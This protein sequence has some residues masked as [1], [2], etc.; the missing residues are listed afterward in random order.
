LHNDEDECPCCGDYEACPDC[1]G[2]RYDQYTD[3]LL[4]CPT[5]D[6]TGMNEWHNTF[7]WL[8][9][10]LET[11]RWG[12]GPLERRWVQSHNWLWNTDASLWSYRK[13][14]RYCDEPLPTNWR[15]VN[16]EKFPCDAPGGCGGAFCWKA[17]GFE[18]PPG[19]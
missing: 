15:C 19:R 18:K 14:V 3:R 9:V 8:P 1:G 4:D 13:R 6:G 7:A 16:P 17:R 11:G 5:C 10:K 12:W 2:A